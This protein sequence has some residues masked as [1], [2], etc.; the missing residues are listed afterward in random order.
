MGPFLSPVAQTSL[1]W[2]QTHSPTNALYPFTQSYL[3]KWGIAPSQLTSL[4]TGPAPASPS[5]LGP[6]C[7]QGSAHQGK[8]K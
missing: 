2:A 1:E 7:P 6:G 5:S 4:L 3:G 8:G